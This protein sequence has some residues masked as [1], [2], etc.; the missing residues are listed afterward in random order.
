MPAKDSCH[1]AISRA[2]QKDGWY[3]NPRQPRLVADIF[4]YI[5]IEAHKAEQ[6]VFIEVK[7]F[8]GANDTQELY[9]AFGQYVVYRE[10]VAR[11]KPE[12]NLYL[13]IPE[14]VYAGF[15]ATI[16][17]TIHNNHVKIIIVDIETEAIVRWMD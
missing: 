5:D 1:D 6:N 9:I 13:G 10:L 14:S 2:L 7:C 4:A 8:P 12:A 16:L 3:I 15:T 17:N 11:L